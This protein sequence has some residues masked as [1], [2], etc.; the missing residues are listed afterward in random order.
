M[1]I[2]PKRRGKLPKVDRPINLRRPEG[3]LGGWRLEIPGKRPLATAA[4]VNNRVFLGGGF[5]SYEFYCLDAEAGTLLWQYQTHD[6]G[7]TAAVVWEDYVVFNTESCELEVLTIAGKSVWKQWLGDPLMSMPAIAQGRIF[8]A[9]PDTRGD[10]EHYLSCFDITDGRSLWRSRISGEIITAPVL[11]E[12][13][14]Y[15]AT[16]DGTLYCFAQNSGVLRWQEDCNATSSPVVVDGQC[17]FTQ[18]KPVPGK[19]ASSDVQQTE[20]CAKRTICPKSPIHVYGS[21]SRIADYLDHRMRRSRSAKSALMAKADTAVGFGATKGSS[22][23]HQAVRNLGHGSVAEVWGYQGSKPFFWRNRLFASLGDTLH[24]LDTDTGESVW[25]LQ[26]PKHDSSPL[27]DS[28]LTPPAIAN[29]KVFLGTAT[30]EL[31]ALSAETGKT[32]WHDKVD[33]TFDFQLTVVQGRVY[34]PSRTGTLFCL[35]T[36]DPQDDGWAMWGATPQHNGLAG[37]HKA[38]S[39]SERSPR[40]PPRLRHAGQQVSPV[41]SESS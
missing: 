19:T 16:L 17:Y 28:V 9:Y 13:A 7:P 21:T 33:A 15:L 38:Q 5:G 27:V 30:G 14:V 34:A 1:Q 22:K 12:D 11:A 4:V 8:M 3:T 25:T 36:G 31:L 35:E 40:T 23:I 26:L 37:N 24:C 39:S 41:L 20:H 29:E 6:D 18:R 32:L 10:H 2:D